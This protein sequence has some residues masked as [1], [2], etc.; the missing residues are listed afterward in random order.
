MPKLEWSAEHETLLLEDGSRVSLVR[1]AS[2]IP[3]GSE[4][5]RTGVQSAMERLGGVDLATLA[6]ALREASERS[7]FRKEATDLHSEL[8]FGIEVGSIL[9][10]TEPYFLFEYS[11]IT[12]S[13][14]LGLVVS[15]PHWRWGKKDLSNLI[16]K[17][18][19]PHCDEIESVVR[20]D[21]YDSS[22]GHLEAWL[23][24]TS[25]NCQTIADVVQRGWLTHDI[26]QLPSTEPA[27]KLNLDR[28]LAW[29]VLAAGH[30]QWLVGEYE[31]SW[32]EVK[33]TGYDINSFAGKIELAQDVARFANATEEGILICGLRTK[34][35]IEGDKI[36]KLTPLECDRKLP[37]RYRK[38][39]DDYVYPPLD[40]LHVE[41]FSDRG[42]GC[43]LAVRVPAQRDES[44]PFLVCGAVVDGVSE[45][46][47]ISI[48]RRSGEHSI[49]TTAAAIHAYLSAGRKALN[50]A[51]AAS[52]PEE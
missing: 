31:S 17:L 35:T 4:K 10:R 36:V 45:G 1:D 49:P 6:T 8:K 50:S 44:K 37:V 46:A 20:T 7:A 3:P 33:S 40:G 25:D 22:P 48:V 5:R 52:I 2:P 26:V 14:T 18:W 9:D 21:P 11:I 30:P 38:V 41:M 23:A 19:D 28:G 16:Q 12:G 24:L 13:L 27:D 42:G 39:I 43:Y 15:Y 34:R 51:T 29:K 47:F 32:L